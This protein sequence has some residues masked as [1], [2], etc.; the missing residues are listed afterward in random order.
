MDTYNKPN[1]KSAAAVTFGSYA[2]L[3]NC[4]GHLSRLVAAALALANELGLGL[5]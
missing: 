3:A 1:M 2:E 4:L 5:K